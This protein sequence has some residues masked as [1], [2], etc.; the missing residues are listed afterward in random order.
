MKGPV[1]LVDDYYNVVA[2][3]IVLSLSSSIFHFALHFRLQKH[4]WNLL[5]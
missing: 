2:H 4:L 5:V 3:I 1:L